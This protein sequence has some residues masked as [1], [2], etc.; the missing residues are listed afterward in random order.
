[1]ANFSMI[2]DATDASLKDF[3][4][5]PIEAPAGL[6]AAGGAARQG[7]VCPA[8]RLRTPFV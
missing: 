3:G 1:M 2:T 8:V 7:F 6:S 5:N 4:L